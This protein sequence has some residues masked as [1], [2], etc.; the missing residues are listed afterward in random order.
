MGYC[1]YLSRSHPPMNFVSAQP[2][3]PG[4]IDSMLTGE[5]NLREN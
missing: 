4:N 5:L 2:F 1:S 3:T